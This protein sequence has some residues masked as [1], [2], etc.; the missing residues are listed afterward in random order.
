MRDLRELDQYRDEAM[1]QRVAG[2]PTPA[3]ARAHVGVFRV[4]VKT[5]KKPLLIIASSGRH[6][7]SEGWEHVSVSLPSRC[8][9]WE[10]MDLVKRMF[11]LPEEL[12]FQLHPPEAENISNHRF[13]LHIWRPA[14]SAFPTPPSILVGVKALGELC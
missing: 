5:A 12:A 8:P 10:E 6:P 1:E 9:T 2:M 11:F 7:M 3:H 4:R 13:C 14:D